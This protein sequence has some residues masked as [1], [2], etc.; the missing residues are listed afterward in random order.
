M[1]EPI[2]VL[3]QRET[4]EDPDFREFWKELQ[5]H[6]LAQVVA[7]KYE[8]DPTLLGKHYEL[9]FTALPA[10]EAHGDDPARDSVVM[11]VSHKPDYK[12]PQFGNLLIPENLKG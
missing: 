6:H 4:Q 10:Y 1:V 3:D 11:L 9:N 7:G 5:Q 8:K 12:T 2:Q